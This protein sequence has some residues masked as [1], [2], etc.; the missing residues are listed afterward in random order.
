M[1]ST[2][3]KF[4]MAHD[5]REIERQK[6]CPLQICDKREKCWSRLVVIVMRA[7]KK[8]VVRAQRPAT[9]L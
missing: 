8:K 3:Q 6:L 1:L 9:A 5:K 4:P 2:L 7:E